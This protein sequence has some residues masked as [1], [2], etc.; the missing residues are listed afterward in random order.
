MKFS[1]AN[2]LI[3]RAMALEDWWCG[4]AFKYDFDEQ[5]LRT[6]DVTS[7]ELCEAAC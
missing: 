5:D 3:A 6:G 4:S 2:I 7:V 1:V